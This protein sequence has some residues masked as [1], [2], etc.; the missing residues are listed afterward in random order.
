MLCTVINFNGYKDMTK[1]VLIKLPLVIERTGK[2]RSSI[3]A[4]IKDGTFVKPVNIG[5]R[6]IGFVE[7][8]IDD[9]IQERITA[10]RSQ[11]AS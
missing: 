4:G 5:E 2:S 1:A 9:W 10:S 7:S 11:E 8:E 6:A 3:Y